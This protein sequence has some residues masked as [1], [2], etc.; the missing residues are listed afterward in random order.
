MESILCLQHLSKT[1]PPRGAKAVFDRNYRETH[2]TKAVIDVSFDI[3]EGE[4]YGLL[5]PNGAGKST[6]IKM[7][8]GLIAKD[9][10][11][12]YVNGH[13]MDSD[14]EAVLSDIG[15]IIETP[16]MFRGMSA[17]D[18]LRYL[19]TLSGNVSEENIVSALDVVGLADRA[20]D[21][22]ET[23]S[24]GM[25]QRLGIA[26]AIMVKPKLL[27][28][29]EPTNGLDPEWII[30]IRESLRRLSTDYGVAVLVCS[31]ILG[32]MQLL[33]DRVGVLDRGRL[34]HEID[35]RDME[36]ASQD[37]TTIVCYETSEVNR[38]FDIASKMHEKVL[39]KDGKLY[40]E[41]SERDIPVLTKALVMA[42]INVYSAYTKKRNLEEI[43]KTLVI[44]ARGEGDVDNA[45]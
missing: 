39:I 11:K 26:Q 10:G 21:K 1:Y 7:I 44:S 31:H 5:G 17:I 41:I 43:F 37:A 42:D 20:N 4:I 15:A 27:V 19:A 9:T 33:C 6:I 45:R 28:L 36:R 35:I 3:K 2:G 23:Y 13:D 38:A 40:V 30:R 12:I 32:E 22:L 18:N 25:K 14:R 24:L 16:A 8:A 29:D 34:L